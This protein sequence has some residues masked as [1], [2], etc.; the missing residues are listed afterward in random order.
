MPK[1]RHGQRKQ[2]KFFFSA[3]TL[4]TEPEPVAESEPAETEITA[5]EKTEPVPQ[6]NPTS[7]AASK[8]APVSFEPKSGD[9]TVIDG[10]PHIWIP[11]FGW[12]EDQG[13]GSHGTVA[14]DMYEK[15]NKIGVMGGGTTVGNPATSLPATRLASWVAAQL[16]TAKAI[17]TSR[18]ELWAA[19]N[20]RESQPLSH[21]RSRIRQATSFTS[22]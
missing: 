17:S 11:G 9:K 5:E 7:R 16:F 3:D 2:H 19:K 18:L 15:G 12:I 20:R 8:S 1:L 6:A 13:G 14:K 22:S 21:P 10:K 4:T